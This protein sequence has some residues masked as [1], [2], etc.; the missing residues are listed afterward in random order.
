MLNLKIFFPKRGKKYELVR[1]AFQNA[2]ELLK[3]N[4]KDDKI[5]L[6]IKEIFQLESIPF[7]IEIFDNSHL[8]GVSPVGA[9]VVYENNSFKK[10]QYRHY[11]LNSKNE[12]E[13]MQELLERRAESFY[14]NPPPDLWVIDGGS[15]LLNLAK[16]VLKKHN[17]RVDVIAIA[18]EKILEKPNSSVF[19]RKYNF[20]QASSVNKA[21]KYLLQKEMIYY[22]NNVYK[23]YDVFLS[24]WLETLN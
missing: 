18:K 14:K 7:R 21:L 16:K 8:Q 24:K 15:V 20:T 22:E 23:V 13:Q 4:S 10:N 1:L 11:N 12:Y 2:L 9:M 6:E 3:N 19:L 17:V 5:L